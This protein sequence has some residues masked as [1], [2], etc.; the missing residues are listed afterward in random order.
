MVT[1]PDV[2]GALSAALLADLTGARIA[3]I[4]TTTRLVLLGITPGEALDALWL[5][6]DV[7]EPRIRCVGQHL[8][9]HSPSDALPLRSVDS[10]NPNHYFG[11]S[12]RD[13]FRGTSASK[14][15]KYPFATIHFLMRAFGAS[16]PREGGVGYSLLAHADGA[17]S[18]PLLY[19][20]NT[21]AWRDLMFAGDPFI[22]R[23]CAGYTDSRRNLRQHVAVVAHLRELGVRKRTSSTKDRTHLIPTNWRQLVGWQ[24]IPFVRGH[25]ARA[26][27]KYGSLVDYAARSMGWRSPALD[28]SSVNIVEGEV[29]SPFPGS[30]AQGAFDDFMLAEKIFSHAITGARRLRYTKN[31]DL[32]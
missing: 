20:W 29:C 6:H 2:D 3:G 25:H 16:Y 26:L 14:R 18:M 9:L 23:L 21:N 32:G 24:S 13:S 19:P 5:D 17:W 30:I 27:S 10:F 15:D 11:Q 22:G 4:Y 12:F 28:L 1:S 7:S 31:L 8:I